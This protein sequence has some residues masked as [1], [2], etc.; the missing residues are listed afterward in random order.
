MNNPTTT[1]AGVYSSSRMIKH[2]HDTLECV[3]CHMQIKES[4]DYK[5]SDIYDFF[6][7]QI[8]LT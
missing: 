6:L 3:Q 5:R 8:V 1:E 2:A 7:R 4:F